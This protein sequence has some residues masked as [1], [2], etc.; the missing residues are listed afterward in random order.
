MQ[1]SAGVQCPHV[2]NEASLSSLRPPRP[3]LSSGGLVS[4]ESGDE[5]EVEK[6]KPHL[7]PGTSP[8]T[9]SKNVTAEKLWRESG[10]L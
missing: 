6:A 1:P 5:G 8:D 10:N 9:I 3:K 4:E 2:N 7:Q